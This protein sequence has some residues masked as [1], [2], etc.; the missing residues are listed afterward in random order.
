MYML[1]SALA[2][3]A[4]TRLREMGGAPRNPAPL[5]HF[6]VWI[7]KPSGYHCTDGHLTSRVFTEDQQISPSADPPEEHLPFLSSLDIPGCGWGED[8]FAAEKPAGRP[9][10][11]PT[12]LKGRGLGQRQ[13]AWTRARRGVN[14]TVT[15][16]I[17]INI[18]IGIRIAIAMAR[19]HSYSYSHGHSHRRS[20]SRSHG[21]SHKHTI[22]CVYLCQQQQHTK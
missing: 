8:R 3:K 20:N 18:N 9:S 13:A 15:V 21:H 19:G 7:V 17:A 16:T 2:L 12:A 5:N 22:T 6:S 4:P 14:V 10:C 11:Q 1:M